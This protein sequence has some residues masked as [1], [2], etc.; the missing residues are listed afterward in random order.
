MIQS[1]K[2]LRE[3]LKA[4]RIINKMGNQWISRLTFNDNYPVHH[5][6]I[7]LRHVEYY[8]NRAKWY[9]LPLKYWYLLRYRRSQIKTDMVIFPNTADAGLRLI[10]PG[11]RRID[12]MVKIGKNCQIL[13]LVLFGRKRPND[14]DPSIN[15]GD[16]C[17]I[18][19][20]AKILGPVNI[21]NNVTIAAGAVVLDD[22]P[23]NAVVGGVPA[24]ILKIK[25]SQNH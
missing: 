16:N 12:R 21:G 5:H 2:D 19:V 25:E 17:Y 10:H 13:P 22:I 20:G 23:D 15:M 9:E 6:L 18:G 11:F 7:L 3:Y 8:L 4:D 14:P 24:K 1:R